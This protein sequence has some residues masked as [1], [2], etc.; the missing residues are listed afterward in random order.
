MNK[1][2]RSDGILVFDRYYSRKPKAFALIIQRI[3]FC[4]ALSAVSMLYIFS[5]FEMQIS[6]FFVGGITALFTALLSVLFVFL[7]RRYVIPALVLIFAPII[8]FNFDDF[9]LRF[10]YFVDEAMLLVDGRILHPKPFLIHSEY[11]LTASNP[12]YSEGVALGGFILCA[13]YAM[14][15]AGSMK[16]RVRTFPALAGFM[17]LWIPSLFAEKLEIN[18]WFVFASILFAAAAAIELNYKDGLAVTGAG[19]VSYKQQIKEEERSFLKATGKA[20]L[21]KRIGMRFSFYSKYFAS[22]IFCAAIFGVCFIVGMSVFG[23]RSC[24]DYSSFYEL[25]TPDAEHGDDTDNSGNVTG[26]FFTTPSKPSDSLNITSPGRGNESIIKVTFTGDKNIYLRGDI[27]V[28]FTGTGWTTPI[29]SKR[30]NYSSLKDTYRPAEAHVMSAVLSALNLS[31]HFNGTAVSDITIEY[32][33]Q[34]DVVFLPSYTAD[35]SYYDSPYF[36]VYGDF[37]VRV[38]DSA[39]RFVNSVQCTAILHDFSG[40]GLFTEEEAVGQIIKSYRSNNITVDDLYQSVIPEMTDDGVFSQYSEY[41][42][43][44]YLSVPADIKTELY[45]FIVDNDLDELPS[46]RYDVRDESHYRYV[47]AQTICDFLSENYAYSLS[48]ENKGNRALMQFLTETKRGH[49]SLYASAMTLILRELKI[50]ARYCTGFSIYPDSVLGKTVT[51]KQ[52]NLHA[53]VEVY[54][55][56]LGWVT[57]DPTASAVSAGSGTDR[58]RDDETKES[59]GT[60]S[61]TEEAPD[62]KP[63]EETRENSSYDEKDSSIPK[64]D[65]SSNAQTSSNAADEDKPDF[66]LPLWL[67]ITVVAALAIILCAALLITHCRRLKSDAEAALKKAPYL[68]AASV[69]N[70]IIEL[71]YYYE[72]CPERGQLPSDYYKRCDELFGAGMSQ[73]S[74]LLEKTAFGSCEL[75]EEEMLRLSDI[76]SKLYRSMQ[77]KKA[78]MKKYHTAKIVASLLTK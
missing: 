63:D 36:D 59:G 9:W 53:W 25:F 6:L 75:D 13:L 42:M 77:K 43:D 47:A 76:L 12:L 38:S 11:L 34:T 45:Q 51:L 29:N 1:R 49:C 50:P 20:K 41:V 60:T 17:V 66:E 40:S 18:I 71:L 8:Y 48:G 22:G 56:E 54:I 28:N 39:D 52:K 69:Y 70:C 55:D 58:P 14:L 44:T 61:K 67:V 74:N 19:A 21:F 73:N 16:K 31:D 26:D 68:S 32:I 15:C 27:G 4:S 7:G 33:Q 46:F 35:F 24:I 65:A 64:P 62:S 57:F 3:L 2:K 72:A 10:S 5:Q 78:P 30:W 37:C 23:E